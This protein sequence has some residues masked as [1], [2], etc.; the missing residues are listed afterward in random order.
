MAVRIEFDSTYNIETP[1]FVLATR[2]GTPLGSIPA[3]NIVFR[4]CL[5]ARSE[6]SFKVNKT[7]NDTEYHLWDKLQNLKLMWCRDWNKWFEIYVELDESTELVKNVTA[8]SLGEA[9]LSQ[10]NLYEFECNTETEIAKED[11]KPTVL[12]DEF[13]PEFSLLHR[14]MSKAAHYKID[15]VDVSIASI[16]RTFTFDSVSLYDAM[17]TVSQEI[18]CLFDIDVVTDSDGN[19]S[20]T[21]SVYDLE[22]FCIDCGK[23][24]EFTAVCPECGSTNILTGYGT[25]T[26]I[27]VDTENLADNIIYSTDIG[28][29]KN[30][31]RLVAGDDLMTETVQNCNPNGSGYIWFIADELKEDMSEELV[32]RLAEYDENYEYYN[33]QHVTDLT[34][35]TLTGF[36]DLITK[37]HSYSDKLQTLDSTVTGYPPLIGVYY[38]ALDFYSFLENDLNAVPEMDRTSAKLQLTNLNY[39]S[40]SPVAVKNLKN[41]SADNVKSSVLAMAQTLIDPRYT[42]EIDASLYLPD[43]CEWDGTFKVTNKENPED[44]ATGARVS[45]IIT[46]DF[47]ELVTEKLEKLQAKQLSSIPEILQLFKYGAEDFIAYIKRYSL[48]VLLLLSD[49][50]QSCLDTLIEEGI[51]DKGAWGNKDPDLY[52]SIYVPYYEKLTYIKEE[53]KLR[54]TEIAA[55]GAM[56]SIIE[57]YKNEI[58]TALDFEAFLGSE[59]WL[60][61]IAYRREDTHKNE[62]YISEGLTNAELF[63]TALEFVEVAKKEI[64]KSATLQHSISATLKNLLVMKEFKPLVD[65]FEVGNW[66]RVCVD[67]IIYRLRLLDYEIDF[68]NLSNIAITFSDVKVAQDDA[69]D[70]NSV[71]DMAQSMAT[72]YP[73]IVR[74]TGQNKKSSDELDNWVTKGL[75]LTKMKIIDSAENQNITFDSHGL[76]CKEYSPITDSYDDKQLKLINRGLYLTDDNWLSSRA[77]I[78]DFTFYNPMTGQMEETYGVIA[79]TLVGNLI[80]SEKVGIYNTSNSITLDEYGATITTD[81]T[82]ANANQ[83]AFTIQRKELDSNGAEQITPVMFVDANGELV[84]NG[85]IRINSAADTNVTT[86][87]D[88]TDTNRWTQQIN[89]AVHTEAQIIYNQIDAK[90]IDVLTETTAQLDQYKADIGQYM[91]FDENGLTLGAL[92]SDFKA[93]IDNQRL[94]FK[95]GETVVSYISNS[96]LYITDAVINNTLILG[97]F[98]FS[99]RADGGVSLTWQGA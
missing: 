64:I 47:G 41:L 4:D 23:R 99:P 59:L 87:D 71:L 42:V 55:V 38:D 46:D 67:G 91:Q 82:N 45:V 18:N 29:V 22:S 33:T 13:N 76:L 77:G 21:V 85:S 72:S 93:V 84:L 44:T 3:H 90:Y 12:Y 81:G 60:E 7:D 79:D 73:S 26:T 35:D 69:S 54:K 43:S 95:Q 92:T 11:Y 98:F 94:A 51:A 80:L 52:R 37:Y 70:I 49:T 40:L 32:K 34:S 5:N 30:C 2:N 50:C 8:K 36:N 65:Y 15:H 97:D 53:I 9:E 63:E 61:F 96:Q 56:L 68:N 62:N 89:E 58:Q 20:R 28:A 1:V 66:I 27:Y 24:D 25:D 31:F 88:L 19:I 16:Q 14:M 39:A 83:I 75:A 57:K 78:G 17:Q 74:Q 48:S 6:L 10:I 86:L